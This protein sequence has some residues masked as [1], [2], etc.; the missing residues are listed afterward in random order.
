MKK[1]EKNEGSHQNGEKTILLQQGTITLVSDYITVPSPV[2]FLSQASHAVSSA[3]SITETNIGALSTAKLTP[4]WSAYGLFRAHRLIPS[5][6]EL[7]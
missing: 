2:F 1:K 6:T 5:R 7:N 3:S 4:G